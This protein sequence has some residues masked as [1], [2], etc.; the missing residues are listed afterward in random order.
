MQ[1]K[2]YLAM[3]EEDGVITIPGLQQLAK[4]VGIENVENID[5]KIELIQSIQSAG[6]HRPCFRSEPGLV[7][8]EEECEWKAECKKLIAG[9]CR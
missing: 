4:S 3:A 5:M 8:H 2:L 1:V 9:W 6:H 7:C